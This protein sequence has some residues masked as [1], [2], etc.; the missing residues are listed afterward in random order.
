M[1]QPVLD[2][3]AGI[4]KQKLEPGDAA[5]SVAIAREV[6]A[7]LCDS[8]RIETAVASARGQTGYPKSIHW[9]PTSLAQGHVGL[10]LLCGYLDACFPGEGWDLVGLKQ[11]KIAARAAE[12]QLSP[13]YSM[14]SGLGGLA[15][16]ALYLS[17]QGTRYRKL[18]ASIEAALLRLVVIAAK[19][20]RANHG[21]SVSTFDV[22]SGLSGV[23]GYLLLR[24]ADSRHKS[25]LKAVLRSLVALTEEEGGLPR[26]HTPPRYISDENSR[27]LYPHGNLNCGL[28]HGIPGPLALLSIAATAGVTVEGQREAIRRVAAWLYQY[29]MDDQ[30][31]LNW[32]TAVPI[33]PEGYPP[34]PPLIAKDER[35]GPAACWP[36]RAAWCY[37]SPGIARALWLAGQALNEVG[38]Q[39]LAVA[40]MEAV[41]RRPVS[42]RQIDSPTFCHGV[43]GLQQITLRFAQ[44]TALPLFTEAGRTLH[45]QILANYEPDSVLGYRNLEPGGRRI[46][47]A[48]LLD[49]AP[50][51]VL[52][53]LAASTTVEPLWDRLFLLS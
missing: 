33:G 43:A 5:Q 9:H 50:G 45:R 52:V 2:E 10:G 44:D 21:V 23:G 26:W 47:Q 13:T 24:R 3:P 53:L 38:Y 28:A 20:L 30:W 19:S 31:G 41:Y 37:G 1:V 27:Q 14:Y 17:R 11:L 46:D 12:R 32:P 18:L 4:W 6:A 7:R 42:A 35:E 48:G 15:L 51:V 8:V 29:H 36:S 16:T 39:E 40:A 49:G 34:R 25:V 22:I